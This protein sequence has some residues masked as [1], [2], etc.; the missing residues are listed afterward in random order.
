MDAIELLKKFKSPL[1]G[2]LTD[3]QMDFLEMMGY[4]EYPLIQSEGVT[5]VKMGP[6]ITDEGHFVLDKKS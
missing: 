3:E 2:K 5:K 4:I 6:E 1:E